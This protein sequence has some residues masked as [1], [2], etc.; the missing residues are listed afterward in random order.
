MTAH[1]FPCLTCLLVSWN[2][3]PWGGSPVRDVHNTKQGWWYPCPT[4]QVPLLNIMLELFDWCGSQ[5]TSHP[6]DAG[7]AFTPAVV[8]G[9]LPGL[10]LP[11]LLLSL[12]A[13]VRSTRC[14]ERDPTLLSPP[15]GPTDIVAR[16]D[17]L[18]LELERCEGLGALPVA[19]M[20]SVFYLSE[21]NMVGPLLRVPATGQRR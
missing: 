4:P 13:F 3:L 17:D 19:D 20:V 9:S 11:S 21:G 14:G 1:V 6:F 5:A 12:S 8:L 16:R 18:V 15:P 10:P 7:L 2:P